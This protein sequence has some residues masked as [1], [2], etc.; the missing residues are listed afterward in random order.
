MQKMLTEGG[1]DQ[2]VSSTAAENSIKMEMEI[3][4]WIEQYEDHW[5]P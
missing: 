1:S 5:W 3:D 2:L 4:H